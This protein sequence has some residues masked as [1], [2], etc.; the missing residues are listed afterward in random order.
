M[1]TLCSNRPESFGPNSKLHPNLPT[2]CFLDVIV[3]P[4]PTWL[5]LLTTPLIA[6]NFRH[7]KARSLRDDGS[8]AKSRVAKAIAVLYYILVFAMLA[9][10]SL[11]IA[12]LS[13][14]HLG[15]GLLPFTYIGVLTACAIHAFVTTR[16]AKG[17]S[18]LFWVALA[19][20]MAVKLST[21]VK[22]EGRRERIGVAAKYPLG[23]QVTDN[24]V[25]VGVEVVLAALEIAAR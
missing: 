22:E 2:T 7:R 24:G 14:A 6:L 4:L 10:E 17:A 25:M 13:V 5:F 3:V 23:D 12:R 15:I 11:E 16:L 18:A 9:M 8:G 1:V 21:L 19:A 20:A